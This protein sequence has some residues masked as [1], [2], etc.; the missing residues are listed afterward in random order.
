MLKTRA[1]KSFV[2]YWL[3]AQG[4]I[5]GTDLKIWHDLRR[6][7]NISSHPRHQHIFPPVA[8]FGMFRHV[9]ELVNSLF[10]AA[11]AD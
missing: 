9:A 2:P 6:L 10:P 8:V 5:P 7:R 1:D 3:R 11:P 4:A